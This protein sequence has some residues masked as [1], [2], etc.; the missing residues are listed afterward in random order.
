MTKKHK[1]LFFLWKI[2]MFLQ[3]YKKG[4]LIKSYSSDKQKWLKDVVTGIVGCSV[5]RKKY[6]F[7]FQV[8]YF[9][10]SQGNDARFFSRGYYEEKDLHKI[11]LAVW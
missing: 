8:Q 5:T 6:D 4:T 9:E 1:F 11:P 10:P 2:K 7:S 3:G